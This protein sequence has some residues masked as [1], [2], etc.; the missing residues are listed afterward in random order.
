[1]SVK[2][3]FFS[4]LTLCI[5]ICFTFALSQNK[6]DR[7]GLKP[8]FNGRILIKNNEM[9]SYFEYK[10]VENL[11]NSFSLTLESISPFDLELPV[12]GKMKSE[13]IPTFYSSNDSQLNDDTVVATTDKEDWLFF[14]EIDGK[15]FNLKKVNQNLIKNELFSI[16]IENEQIISFNMLSDSNRVITILNYSNNEKRS[17][18]S[19][20]M[21]AI[22]G[23]E[24][25]SFSLEELEDKITSFGLSDYGNWC[26]TNNTR[27]DPN[28]PT[29]DGVDA[30]CRDHDL[31]IA[32]HGYHSCS[33]DG[34]FIR[35][36]QS[37]SARN[38]HGETYRLGAI[39]LFQGKVCECRYEKCIK[40]CNFRRCWKE[41]THLK[42]FGIGGKC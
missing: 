23:Y 25:I 32:K 41:C 30:A 2:S 37:A 40:L 16:R 21:C 1:M 38:E 12:C 31:C 20:E 17:D 15:I 24:S 26:G 14:N 11:S 18:K 9:Y 4:L 27:S 13:N 19:P 35:N 34:R 29:E 3:N 36:L 33:C 8:S 22:L 5:F 28:Y 6:S 39:A 42:S 10:L 7:D